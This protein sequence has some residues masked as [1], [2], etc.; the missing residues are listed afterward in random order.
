MRDYRRQEIFDQDKL[1]NG[2][3]CILGAGPLT[4]YLCLYLSGLGIKNVKVIDNMPYQKDKNEFL[5]TGYKGQKVDGLET[6]VKEINPE[7]NIKGLNSR[8]LDFLIESPDVLVDLTNDP[9]SKKECKA[10]SR[11]VKGIKKIISASSSENNG[12]IRI[13]EVPKT[14]PLILGKPKKTKRI[15]LV[16]DNFSLGMYE[17]LEQGNFTSGLISAIVL[18]EIRKAILPLDNE[19]SLESKVDFSL[20]SENRFNSGLSFNENRDN[21]SKKKVL[22]VGAGGIGTYV[23][24]NLALMGVGSIDLYDGD[25]VEDHNLNRQVFY[26]DAIGKHK[27]SALAS[28]INKIT[29][30]SYIQ[31]HDNY[32]KDISKLKKYDAIFSC[33]DNM[34]YRLMLNKYSI[35]EHIPF[36]NGAVTTFNAI[37]DFSNCYRCEGGADLMLAEEKAEENSRAGCNNI[38]ESNVVM[39]NAFVGALMASEIKPLMY[40][41]KYS[42][43]HGK[44]L[45]YNSKAVDSYKFDVSSQILSC[46]CHKKTN[47]CDC[48]DI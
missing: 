27:A 36:V 47:G 34:E 16:N 40:P 5:L 23:C 9:Y 10:I 1:E 4:N 33:L 24:L 37:A 17:G 11:K 19:H 43:L 18:D 35:E 21:L 30:K 3:V 32:L 7:L 2:K 44:K 39:A 12:S 46:L 8:P 26:Y 15:G 29:G 14:E 28:R 13:Y 45:T 42:S 6:K 41:K 31:P 25:I 20:Y 22:V 48:H 38:R